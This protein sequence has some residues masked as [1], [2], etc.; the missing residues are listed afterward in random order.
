M[1]VGIGYDSH[2]FVPDRPFD[3]KLLGPDL[4][5]AI[6]GASPAE[7]D[8]LEADHADEI[9][10]TVHDLDDGLRSGLLSLETLERVDLWARIHRRV[11]ESLAP[12][13]DAPQ[14]RR[15]DLTDASRSEG[16]HRARSRCPSGR[17]S[18]HCGIGGWSRPAPRR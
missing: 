12:D 7:V 11:R 15:S 9:A 6:M 8:M 4:A 1:R 3:L 5:Q 18:G 2:K 10:Y 14:R 13:P 17:A 16:W